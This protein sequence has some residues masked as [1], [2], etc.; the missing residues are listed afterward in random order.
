MEQ[1][2]LKQLIEKARKDPEFFHALVFDPDKAVSHMVSADRQAK[3]AVYGIQPEELLAKA[4]APA[5]S[6][7]L[8]CTVTCESSCGLTCLGKSCN[9]TCGVESCDQTCNSARSCGVTIGLPV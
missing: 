9:Y 2:E 7:S 5:P 6:P 3:A 8:K 4:L 1:D